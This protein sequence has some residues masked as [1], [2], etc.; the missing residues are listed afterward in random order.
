[1]TTD[2]IAAAMRAEMQSGIESYFEGWITELIA[3]LDERDQMKARIAELEKERD[4]KAQ[5]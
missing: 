2:E 3:I 1:M 5:A 4:E